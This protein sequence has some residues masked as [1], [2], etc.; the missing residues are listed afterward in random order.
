[1]ANIIALATYVAQE[2]SEIAEDLAEIG[3]TKNEDLLGSRITRRRTLGKYLS[4]S[5]GGGSA[6][7]EFP[8]QTFILDRV[9]SENN[10]IVTFE[11]ASLFDLEGIQL[12]NR[13]VVGKYCSWKYQGEEDGFG[14][15][16][17][18]KNSNNLFFR[19]DNSIITGVLNWVSA[20][21]YVTDAEVKYDNKI[22]KAI[23]ASSG[24]I[25]DKSPA[26]WTRIDSCPKTLSGCKV[27]FEYED[28]GTPLP[29]GGFPGTKKFR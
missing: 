6:P 24:K 12:P 21:S 5:S 11:L 9:S 29:F 1:M 17:W 14:G 13:F 10:V 3:V 16:T 20:S 26:F 19:A 7:V 25:P 4:S 8:S 23:R 18:P 28:K 2:D 22:W 27:R 15:C